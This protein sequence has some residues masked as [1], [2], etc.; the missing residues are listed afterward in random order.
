M[1]GVGGGQL[2]LGKLNRLGRSNSRGG[3]DASMETVSVDSGGVHV[4]HGSGHQGVKAVLGL[5]QLNQLGV[6]RGGGIHWLKGRRL[7]GDGLLG[8][9]GDGV[10]GTKAVTSVASVDQLRG[11]GGNGAACGENNLRRVVIVRWWR[12]WCLPGTSW[13]TSQ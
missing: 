13:R 1:G 7:V 11:A 3:N 12:R 10:D 5:L 9:C 8:H 4:L 2:N 6:S